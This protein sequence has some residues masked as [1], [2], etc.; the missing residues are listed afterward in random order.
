MVCHD[1]RR[2][3]YY[4]T[5]ADGRRWSPMRLIDKPIDQQGPTM[6]SPQL[7]LD[8]T[9]A[10]LIEQLGTV[11]SVN[12]SQDP[13]RAGEPIIIGS[14]VVPIH[15]RL[16]RDGDDVLLIAGDSTIWLLRSSMIDLAAAAPAP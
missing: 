15:G 4:L 2:T 5:S 10:Y 9:A 13:I 3:L 11:R 1:I 7:L 8:G 6:T 16:M 14:H 12:L